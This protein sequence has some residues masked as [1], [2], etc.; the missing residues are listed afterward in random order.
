MDTTILN[1][2]LLELIEKRVALSKLTYDNKNY[3]VIE[4]EL[5]DLEDD[6]IDEFGEFVEEKLSEVYDEFCPDND[7]LSPIAYIA[8]KY[9][10]KDGNYW[11]TQEEGISVDMDDFPNSD[12]K[13]VILPS[14]FRIVLNIDGNDSRI[15]W[16]IA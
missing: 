9:T 7:V 1:Q 15:V 6:F 11:V 16:P 14:P 4:E 2:A 3:D 5:H 12:T 13:L 8:K 10:K